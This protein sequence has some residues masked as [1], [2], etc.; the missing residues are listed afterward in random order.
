MT[1]RRNAGRATLRALLAGAAAATLILSGAVSAAAE[2]VARTGT[3]AGT[4]TR[5]SDGMPVTGVAVFVSDVDGGFSHNGLTDANGAYTV[6]GLE[7]GE[8]TARFATEGTGSGL[9]SEYWDGAADR[10]SA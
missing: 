6:T 3:I 2:D 4:V 5:E 7:A 1:S 8:Y 9:L 10:A